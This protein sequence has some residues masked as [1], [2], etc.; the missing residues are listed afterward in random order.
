M[1][2]LQRY[3]QR[4]EDRASDFTLVVAIGFDAQDVTLGTYGKAPGFGPAA[5]GRR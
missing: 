1:A 4:L 2:A 3:C 5:A